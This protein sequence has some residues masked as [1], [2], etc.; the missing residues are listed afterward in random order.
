M[1][2]D[3]S[4][5]QAVERALDWLSA[6]QAATGELSSYA[7]PLGEGVDVEWM[8]DSLKFITALI[9][10]AVADVD[11]PRATTIIDGVVGFL[12]SEREHH[13]LW[14][15][16]TSANELFDYTPPD[17]DDTACASMAVALRGDDT[18]ANVALLLANR[19]RAGR[20]FT[21]LIP[22]RDRPAPRFWWAV[23]DEFRR[24][25]RARRQE[26]WT[27][28]EAW[29]DD[30]DGVV[31]ANVVR[32]LGPE[33]A[34]AA[35][36]EFVVSIIADGTEDDCDS[37]HRNRSTLYASVADGHRRGISAFAPLGPVITERITERLDALAA[38][39]ALDC[40]QSLVAL[41]RFGAPS[42][43]CNRLHEALLDSQLQDGSWERSVFYYGGPQEVF[44]WASE[45]LSTAV[46][47]QALSL[48]ND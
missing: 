41:H 35:A 44:G 13:G 43:P 5:R 12:R 22:H 14:R 26:L 46:A 29:P 11:D 16:W 38:G 6:D 10:L 42:A 21:W 20:F 17:A 48:R 28:S 36:V 1:S 27:N 9:A 15:Y 3:P 2:S 33:Y 4:S 37:W 47:I 24:S 32:Y 18:S 40:A 23:R 19:D 39:P 8:P 45:A 7:S 30:V 34:P 25:T 31:N